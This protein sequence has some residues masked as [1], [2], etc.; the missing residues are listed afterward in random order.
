MFRQNAIYNIYSIFIHNRQKLETTQVVLEW[1]NGLKTRWCICT[2]GYHLEIQ[3]N[4]LLMHATAS[5]NLQGVML[6][7]KSHPPGVRWELGGKKR[8]NGRYL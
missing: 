6:R 7:E 3:R 4:N 5:V 1:M 8:E 2:V